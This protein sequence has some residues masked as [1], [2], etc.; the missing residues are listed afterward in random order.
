[1]SIREVNKLTG[2]TERIVAGG[3]LY[4][5]MPISS[6]VKF[7]GQNI[8]S[9]FHASDGSTFDTTKYPELYAQLGSNTLPNN[10]GYIIKMIQTS[11]PADF[12]SK[13][14]DAVEDKQD[15]TLATPLTIG[16]TSQTTV[17]GALGG[18]NGLVPC[19]Y[20]YGTVMDTIDSYAFASF[21]VDFTRSGGWASTAPAMIGISVD[22]SYVNSKATAIVDCGI[23]GSVD[24]IAFFYSRGVGSNFAIV[25]SKPD[26]MYSNKV[27]VFIRFR[28]IS[29]GYTVRITP[30]TNNIDLSNMI[31]TTSSDGMPTDW[32][33]RVVGGT[34]PVKTSDLTS[35]VTSGSTAPITSGG[36][37]DA[38][39]KRYPTGSLYPSNLGLAAGEVNL[40]NLC[41]AINTTI[42]SDC[43]IHFAWDSSSAI[44][45]N[46]NGTFV[47]LAGS[48]L[49]GH[50]EPMNASWQLSEGWFTD[51][52][53]N[54]YSF[55]CRIQ[56]GSTPTI[57]IKKLS[58]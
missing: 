16:G 2:D 4:A 28:T 52:E 38:I 20:I 29:G 42:G 12:Q 34:R 37:Y 22:G 32:F 36:V 9:G 3:T 5:D 13:V 23:E 33:Q 11:I 41:A 18:L 25:G 30:L 50:F 15:K 10:S 26:N 58:S 56:S 48:V 19:D 35:T 39:V 31:V 1:M 21:D 51:E 6:E 17:E 43:C 47:S 14:D 45:L 55:R 40:A 57:A 46:V 54:M 24:R 27:K 8:P 53:G 44:S 7:S 49:Q